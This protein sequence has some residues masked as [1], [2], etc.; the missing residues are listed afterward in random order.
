LAGEAGGTGAGFQ[1]EGQNK[2]GNFQ[3]RFALTIRFMT[4]SDRAIDGTQ[5]NNTSERKLIGPRHLP[6]SGLF[7]LALTG[8]LTHD[9]LDG[10]LA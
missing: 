10:T 1:Q 8:K 4:E 5:Q 3:G 6:R 7:R 9:R 2:V